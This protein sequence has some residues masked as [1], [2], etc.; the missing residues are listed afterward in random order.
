MS[1]RH[2]FNLNSDYIFLTQYIL[3]SFQ[4]KER[5]VDVKK[6]KAIYL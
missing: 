4:D 3:C 2:K 1:H 6:E 5:L